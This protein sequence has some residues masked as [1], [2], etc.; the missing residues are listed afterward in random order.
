MLHLRCTPTRR[1]I[2][3]PDWQA[4]QISSQANS[5]QKRSSTV[6]DHPENFL[7]SLILSNIASM[8]SGSQQPFCNGTTVDYNKNIHVGIPNFMAYKMA[9]PHY[10]IK[11]IY[12]KWSFPFHPDF[13]RVLH[14]TALLCYDLF[15]C[16]SHDMKLSASTSSRAARPNY[17]ET[18]VLISVLLLFSHL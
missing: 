12:S 18:W 10:L 14:C 7:S 11:W 8:S 15:L 2:C 6:N 4:I 3:S 16:N 9:F 5:A 17:S 1:R 13:Q